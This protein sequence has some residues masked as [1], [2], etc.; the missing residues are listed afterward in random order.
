MQQ[1]SDQFSRPKCRGDFRSGAVSGAV[2]KE[3]SAHA[4]EQILAGRDDA[5]SFVSVRREL[6]AAPSPP[7][8]VE[9]G[10]GALPRYSDLRGGIWEVLVIDADEQEQ[11]RVLTALRGDGFVAT[12]CP[13]GTAALDLVNSRGHIPDLVVLASDADAASLAV[14]RTLRDTYTATLPV[15]LISSDQVQCTLPAPAAARSI[16]EI[17]TT[18][19]VEQ[20]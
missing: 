3:A 10:A 2:R 6:A 15:I 5:E 18:R 1:V 11:G 17:C 20:L 12:S 9:E 13:S 7:P 14:C 4:L 19:N 8:N 16:A